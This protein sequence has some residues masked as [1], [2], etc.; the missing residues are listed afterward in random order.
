VHGVFGHSILLFYTRKLPSPT[1]DTYPR[2][3]NPR[4]ALVQSRTNGKV[5]SPADPLS[6]IARQFVRRKGS[7][8]T[9]SFRTA[10]YIRYRL[11]SCYRLAASAASDS[12]CW[13]R[14]SGLEKSCTDF[15]LTRLY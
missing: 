7:A 4:H 9:H 6:Y 1:E 2:I 3:T 14:A 13:L 8:K 10:A 15:T 5:A 12:S 11:H